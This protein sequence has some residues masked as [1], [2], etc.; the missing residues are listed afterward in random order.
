M[1]QKAAIQLSVGLLFRTGGDE[2]YDILPDEVVPSRNSRLSEHPY[3]VPEESEEDYSGGGEY[4]KP[5]FVSRQSSCQTDQSRLSIQDPIEPA[6]YCRQ[7]A[8]QDYDSGED[9]RL[10]N[11]SGAPLII[12]NSIQ[13]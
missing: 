9:H 4:L 3:V 7:G 8:L 11:M 12:E 5:T 13:I 6:S 10:H 2:Y 1:C